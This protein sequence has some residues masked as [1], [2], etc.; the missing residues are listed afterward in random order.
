MSHYSGLTDQQVDPLWRKADQA[1]ISRRRFMALLAAGGATAV[2]ASVASCVPAATPTPMPSPTATP[3]P[4][5]TPAPPVRPIVKPIPPQYFIPL[6][7][8]AEMKFEVMANREYAM[9]ESFFFVRNHST[10]PFVDVSTWKL[11]ITGDGIDKPFDVTYDDLL[12]MP[13]VTVT[14]YV[15]CAGN[16]RSFFDS[17]MNRPAQGGQWRLGAYGVAQWTGVPLSYI[18]QQAAIKSNAVDVMPI[19]LDSTSVE[20]PMPVD[21]AME[22]DTIVAYLMNDGILPTD[23]GFPA[24]MLVPGWVGVSSVKWIGRVNVSLSPLYTEKN[25]NT[26]IFIGPDYQPQPPAQGPVVTTQVM[27]S[28]CCLPWPATLSAGPQKVVG[29]A[30]SPAGKIGRVDVSLD[31]GTTFQPAELTGPNIERA[32]SRWELPFTAQPGEMTIMPRA[33]DDMG[34]VQHDVSQQK[35]NQQG[36]VFGAM[37]PHP[38]KVV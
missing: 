15:E 35:W 38:V 31:G 1:G 8:N 34:N 28:A 9:P 19:G 17:L 26:Y 12:R 10:S 2:L 22:D 18:L 5:P 33:T 30:W 29:Y 23:H 7:T 27:K 24:R 32:G 11:S 13:A 14:R 37:V 25:T 36:Y 4:T 21:R 20:R 3:Q 6:G 16:G